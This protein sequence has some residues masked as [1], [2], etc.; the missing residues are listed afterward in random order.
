MK[1]DEAIEAVREYLIENCFDVETGP[2]TDGRTLVRASEDKEIL[3]S[4][5]LADSYVQD[6]KSADAIKR[7]LK[8][9]QAAQQLRTHKP[10]TRGK[11]LVMT[12]RYWRAS[13]EEN[14]SDT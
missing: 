14:G 12:M 8:N 13:L 9:E 2:G 10:A 4:I 6:V 7:D 5:A 11:Y 1:T 3:G